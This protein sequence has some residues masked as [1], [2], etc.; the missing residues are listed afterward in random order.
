MVGQGLS[1]YVFK[2]FFIPLLTITFTQWQ[3]VGKLP[4]EFVQMPCLGTGEITTESVIFY[5]PDFILQ[6]LGTLDLG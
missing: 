3:R 6:T 5:L 4:N 1:G 2:D